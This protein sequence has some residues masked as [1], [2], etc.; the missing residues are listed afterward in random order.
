MQQRYARRQ[1]VAPRRRSPPR[2]RTDKHK[3]RRQVHLPQRWYRLPPANTPPR[4][5]RHLTRLYVPAC[6]LSTSSDRT[7]RVLTAAI[8][9]PVAAM[10]LPSAACCLPPP[11]CRHHLRQSPVYITWTPAAHTA[12]VR[13]GRHASILSLPTVVT[14]FTGDDIRRPRPALS[15]SDVY[16]ALEASTTDI[17]AVAII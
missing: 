4:Y 6:A 17:P 3:K 1:Q 14:T 16:P 12:W 8:N 5:H 15:Q 7:R 9:S 13:D 2:P 10:I 11:L